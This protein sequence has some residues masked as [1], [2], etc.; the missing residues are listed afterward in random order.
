MNK[1]LNYNKLKNELINYL[2]SY[3]ENPKDKIVQNKLIELWKYY[4][5]TF[6]FMRE[7]FVDAL[8]IGEDILCYIEPSKEGVKQILNKLKN[9]HL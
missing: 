4:F 2:E 8:G 3:L 5:H 6:P 1:E 9:E 7:T